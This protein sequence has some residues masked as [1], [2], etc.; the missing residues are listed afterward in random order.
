MKTKPLL[1]CA[2]MLTASL[3]I[4]H[5][6]KTDY[7]RSAEFYKYTTFM[8]NQEPNLANCVMNEHIINA[9][10][11]ELQGKGL[12][13]VTSNADLAVSANTAACDNPNLKAFYA[14]LPGGWSWIYN[15]SPLPSITVVEAFEADT[16]LVQ[17]FD[18]RT[19]CVVWW[20]AG[21]EIVSEKSEKNVKHLN[22]AIA[23]MFENFPAIRL[24]ETE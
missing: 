23:R 8:W 22:K 9:V 5:H 18:T 21:T 24:V 12:H 1:L 16:L 3:A 15:W 11:A 4:A 6:V 20:G 19:Q 13:L 7:D 2:L 10:N 17:L 14:R